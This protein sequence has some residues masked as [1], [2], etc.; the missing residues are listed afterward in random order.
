MP[1]E[2]GDAVN[3]SDERVIDRRALFDALS[4]FSLGV[5]ATAA[6]AGQVKAAPAADTKS[7]ELESFKYDIEERQRLGR[8]WRLGEGSNRCRTACLADHRWGL[9]AT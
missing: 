7:E 8:R 4:R 3:R 1:C 5:A 6:I 9:Y 2:T